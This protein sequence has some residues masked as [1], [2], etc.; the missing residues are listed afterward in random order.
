VQRYFPLASHQ[1]VL[2]STDTE[3]DQ[4]LHSHLE[5]SIARSYQ[6]I[7]Q[8][9]EASTR[10]E[11]GYFWRGQATTTTGVEEMMSS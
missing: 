1:V 2:L 8:P 4:A 10:V 11:E 3:I 9:G 5:P 7:Y 6:L